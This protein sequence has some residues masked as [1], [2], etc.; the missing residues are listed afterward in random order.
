[1]T[2][3]EVSRLPD[4][5]SVSEP[6]KRQIRVGGGILDP[7]QMWQALPEAL[8][9]LDPRQMARNPV[10]L[11]VEVGSALTTALAI[12][13][14]SVFAWVITVWLWLTVLFANLAEAVAEGR[15]KAQAASL[16]R[17]RSGVTSRRLN[18][19]GSYDIVPGS[20]LRV[21]DRVVCV[22]GDV[23]PGDGDV[24]EG[25]ASVDES[26]VTGESAPV[27][28]SRVMTVR[29]ASTSSPRT[30][31]GFSRLIRRAASLPP[32]PAGAPRTP[33]RTCRPRGRPR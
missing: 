17:T 28:A 6:V 12:A 9:K 26:A 20:S 32:A 23:I 22:A 11:V 4:L 33:P 5:G 8:R 24:T 14:P 21:G 10:M 7:R 13:G 16:R 1:M 29:L 30:R 19:D 27:F 25:I 2:D 3:V 18:A 31:P 15:G